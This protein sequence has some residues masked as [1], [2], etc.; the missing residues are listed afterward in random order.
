MT[1]VT[2][3]LALTLSTAALR[4]LDDAFRAAG[5]SLYLV[6][7]SVR[8][9]LLGRP[10][11]DYDFT[12]DARPDEIRRLLAA[13]RPENV[14]AV[15]EKFGT[16]CAT[17]E[18]HTVQVTSYRGEQYNPKSRK[19]EVTFGVSLEDD[20]ARRD[21]TVNAMAR[22]LRDGPLADPF[23][24]RADLEAGLIRAVR[25]PAERFAEDP[26]RMLRAVRFATTLTFEIEPLTMAAIEEQAAELENISRERVAE[27]M[28]KILLSAQPARGLRLLVEFNLMRHIIP[29]ALPMVE[30]RRSGERRHKDVWSHVLQVVD[31]S[32]ATLEL[33]WAALLHDIAKPET[34]SYKD[35]QVHFFGH[36]VV[37]AR[38]AH[39][40]LTR[41]HFDRATVERVSALVARHMRI[42]TYSD[43]S[44]GAV[45]RFMR[46]AGEQ[47]GDLF[48]LSRAD[49]TS[50]RF[51]RVQ[52]V[53]TNV[54]RLEGRV[55]ELEEQAEIAKMRSPLD[56]HELMLLFGR[57][58]GPWLGKVKNY[59]LDLVLDG[60]LD[61]DDKAEGERVAHAYMAEH[62][63]L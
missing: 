36:E 43:W 10:V 41:L 26:L 31:K 29:E 39:E 13:A 63:E 28:N 11:T 2:A 8:D 25:D 17:L 40:I 53:M 14:Y 45:R 33:R 61:Q 19:P 51:E 54:D 1:T 27:E 60:V 23:D 15:G 34:F 20:L 48:A 37:G 18:G 38:R 56:G 4:R 47:L 46:E 7:G 16:I 22:N 32:P 5:K 50:H 49:I 21:F 59:L 55:R 58:P 24:G 35:G 44:D 42:N 30:M 52:A 62:P 12:T 6:G 57:R 3:T 9:E